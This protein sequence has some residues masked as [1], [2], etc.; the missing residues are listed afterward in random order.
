MMYNVCF[1]FIFHSNS[2]FSKE[3]RCMTA[4]SVPSTPTPPQM[5]RASANSIQFSWSKPESKGG[6]LG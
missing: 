4:P 2:K 5:D 6:N 1:D 3:L